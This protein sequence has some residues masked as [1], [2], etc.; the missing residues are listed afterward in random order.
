METHFKLRFLRNTYFLADAASL[1]KISYNIE[2][3]FISPVKLFSYTTAC[4]LPDM[5]YEVRVD[6]ADLLLSEYV[7]L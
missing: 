6:Y 2:E 4:V 1:N 5:Y 7:I 3:L